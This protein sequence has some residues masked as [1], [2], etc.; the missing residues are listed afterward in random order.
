MTRSTSCGILRTEP[1][2]VQA[3]EEPSIRLI[4]M[5][6]SGTMPPLQDRMSATLVK[7]AAPI[8]SDCTLLGLVRRREG[9][10]GHGVVQCC[11]AAGDTQ[12]QR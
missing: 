10:P 5:S 7:A 3:R 11:S 6:M 4:T 9:H 1:G 8:Y 12:H 2:G